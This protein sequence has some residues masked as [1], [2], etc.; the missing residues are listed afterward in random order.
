MY[1]LVGMMRRELRLDWPVGTRL[2][3]RVSGRSQYPSVDS[4]MQ[5][6]EN[7]VKADDD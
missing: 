5:L 6:N 7:P 1:A 2:G 4:A 3:V